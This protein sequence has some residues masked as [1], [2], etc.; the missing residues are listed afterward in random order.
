MVREFLGLSFGPGIFFGVLIFAP[1]CLIIPLTLDPNS[2]RPL[3]N[4]HLSQYKGCNDSYSLNRYTPYIA[5]DG[6][7][8]R[9]GGNSDLKLR[10]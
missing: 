4:D 9:G 5:R 8:P 2:P 7:F 1:I 3:E 6:H 10:E